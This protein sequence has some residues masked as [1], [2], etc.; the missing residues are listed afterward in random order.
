MVEHEIVVGL[1]VERLD[2]SSSWGEPIWRPVQVLDGVPDVP[3]W[4]VL[5]RGADRVRYFAGTFALKLYSTETAYYR[6]NLL[7]AGAKIWVVLRPDGAEPPIDVVS[8]TVDPTEGEGFT[9]TGT[10]VVD[11]VDMPEAIAAEVARFV[12]ANHVERV[13]EKRKRDK[14]APKMVERPLPPGRTEG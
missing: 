12:E 5:S 10:V 11:V 14:R 8:V 7:D 3:A 6:D 9:S 4:T 1:V 2:P 13:F